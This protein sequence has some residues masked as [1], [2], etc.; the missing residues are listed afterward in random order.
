MCVL[1]PMDLLP[2]P[3]LCCSQAWDGATACV[4]HGILQPDLVS[5]S[6]LKAKGPH[7]GNNSRRPTPGRASGCLCTAQ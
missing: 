4:A 3:T 1:T 7:W 5:D 6:D 2:L